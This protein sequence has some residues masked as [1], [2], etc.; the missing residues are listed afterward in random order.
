M[1]C[2]CPS[3]GCPLT[4]ISYD[5]IFDFN[6][7]GA[8]IHHMSEN[9]WKAFQREG[10]RVIVWVIAQQKLVANDRKQLTKYTLHV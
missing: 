7:T 10:S 8:D 9:C 3:D 5:A 2:G 4:F 6:E 1:F